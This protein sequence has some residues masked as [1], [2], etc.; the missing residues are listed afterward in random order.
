MVYSHLDP[1]WDIHKNVMGLNFLIKFLDKRYFN[2]FY[3]FELNPCLV[4]FIH[5]FLI[6]GLLYSRRT[7]SENTSSKEF[8]NFVLPYMYIQC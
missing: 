2:A 4:N 8:C 3:D 5:F 1:A 7:F 6:L